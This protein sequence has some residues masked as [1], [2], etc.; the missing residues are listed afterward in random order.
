MFTI[1]GAG[2]AI[3][4]E[5]VKELAAR[6]EPIRLVSR[7]PKPS[8]GATEAVAADLSNLDEAIKA[9]SGSRIVFLVQ[10]G[11][12]RFDEIRQGIRLSANFLRRRCPQNS[13]RLRTIG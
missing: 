7:N 9:V 12:P 2:G 8:A 6:N 1:L 11:Q 4:D 3:G 10:D 5:L 13:P